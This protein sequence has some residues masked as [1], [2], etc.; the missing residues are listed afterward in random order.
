[1]TTPF[2]LTLFTSYSSQM[3]LIPT[4]RHQFGPI[5]AAKLAPGPTA[6]GALE[7]AG[8]TTGV[9]VSGALAAARLAVPYRLRVGNTAVPP[10]AHQR[11]DNEIKWGCGHDAGR[12]QAGNHPR[13]DSPTPKHSVANTLTTTTMDLHVGEKRRR[14]RRKNFPGVWLGAGVSLVHSTTPVRRKLLLHLSV[15]CGAGQ[16]NQE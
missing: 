12:C 4:Y 1:M 6:H 5:I 9:A 14:G 3:T 13:Q 15:L 7:A 16:Q 8:A 11:G 2:L 10:V